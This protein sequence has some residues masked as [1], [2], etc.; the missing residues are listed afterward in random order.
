MT[1]YPAAKLAS[2]EE[3]YGTLAACNCAMWMGKVFVNEPEK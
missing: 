1:L 2:A 3:Y